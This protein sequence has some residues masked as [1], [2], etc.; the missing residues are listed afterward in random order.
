MTGL[1]RARGF[2]PVWPWGADPLVVLEWLDPDRTTPMSPR[3]LAKLR[4]GG[5]S[6]LEQGVL[7]VSDRCRQSRPGRRWLRQVL[8]LDLP[9]APVDLDDDMCVSSSH[10]SQEPCDKSPPPLDAPA[11]FPLLSHAPPALI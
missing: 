3:A 8:G 5:L 2:V 9:S 7:I 6:D 4:K 11:T 10:G 1:D